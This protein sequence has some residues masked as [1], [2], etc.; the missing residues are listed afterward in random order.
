MGDVPFRPNP[1]TPF[2]RREGGEFGGGEVSLRVGPKRPA[3]PKPTG[4]GK[5]EGRGGFAPSPGRCPLQNH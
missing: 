4:V 5:I 1:L 2:P 3:N